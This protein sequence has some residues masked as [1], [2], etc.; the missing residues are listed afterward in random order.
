[1]NAHKEDTMDES[2][3]QQVFA[4]Y[5]QKKAFRTELHLTRP[6]KFDV[7]RYM[8][9]NIQATHYAA[10]DQEQNNPEGVA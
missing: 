5:L 9:N 2:I 8:L 1:M 4:Q 6:A 10:N 7:F 3:R